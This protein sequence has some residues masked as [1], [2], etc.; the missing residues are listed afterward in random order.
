MR[1]SRR[2]GLHRAQQEESVEHLGPLIL[3]ERYRSQHTLKR[4]DDAIEE[5]VEQALSPMRV[6][7]LHI[8]VVHPF[9]VG[10]WLR[11]SEELFCGDLLRSAPEHCS[12]EKDGVE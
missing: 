9:V 11:K 6:D 2:S 10:R 12:R 5:F 7:F 1:P 8:R 4:F 3:R